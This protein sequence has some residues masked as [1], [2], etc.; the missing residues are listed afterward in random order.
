MNYAFMS[1]SC[2][3]ATFAEMLALAAQYG[4]D[5]I[6]PRAAGGQNHAV[7]LEASAATASVL[8]RAGG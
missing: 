2:P 3:Q 6:E 8:P 5:G 4:Y 7:E 1:F